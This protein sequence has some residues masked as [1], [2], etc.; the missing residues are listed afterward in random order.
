[1]LNLHFPR[2]SRS[3]S[4]C[5]YFLI[6]ALAAGIARAGDYDFFRAAQFDDVAEIRTM[7]AQG[8]DP[9]RLDEVRGETALIMALHEDSARVAQF[10][11]AQAGV[12][13]EAKAANGST[14]LMMAA[15]MHN[16]VAVEQMLARGAQVNRPG[17]AAMHFA[18]AAGDEAI[19][20]I[21][22][23]HH[24][25][26]NAPSPNRMTPLMIAAR[27]GQQG[28]VRL[29]LEAGADT[30]LRTGDGKTAAEVALERDKG[31]IARDIDNYLQQHPAR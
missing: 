8:A 11:I 5:L 13:L 22:I 14:A 9:N 31:Y 10:L 20:R 27:E 3:L 25:D 16:R 18:A 17:F 6:A 26:I 4:L 7:L 30:S 15:F 23:A 1:M 28:A 21:L 19:L 24:A 2:R 12:D 29:L